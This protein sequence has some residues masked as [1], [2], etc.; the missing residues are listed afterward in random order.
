MGH[1]RIS[2]PTSCS[3]VVCLK[4]VEL[5]L[6]PVRIDLYSGE[7]SSRGSLTDEGAVF[8]SLSAL[9]FAASAVVTIVWCTSMSSM[10]EMPMPGGWTM[11]MAW[12]RMP[13]QTWSGAAASFLGMWVVMMAAMML[14]SLVPT[15]WRYLQAVGRPGEARLG[16]LTALVGVGYFFVWTLFGMAAFPLGVALAAIEMQQPALAARRTDRGR[17]GR[18]D[19]RRVSVH[20]VEGTSPRLLPR[21]TRARA[22]VARRRGH[23]VATRH[24]PRPPLQL[25]LCRV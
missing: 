20:R 8:W 6:S 2:R 10:G 9:L 18:P 21:G 16:L 23:G 4:A 1:W 11:S 17:C 12:M 13:G 15:L 19:C 14:P 5:D 24:A 25:L 7:A 22:H 3:R